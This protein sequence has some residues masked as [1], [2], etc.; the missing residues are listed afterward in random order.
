MDP[1]SSRSHSPGEDAHTIKMRVRLI[2]RGI[3]PTR[4][5]PNQNELSQV[6]AVDTPAS[7]NRAFS[8]TEQERERK[9]T[10][11]RESLQRLFRSIALFTWEEHLNR[12][13]FSDIDTCRDG[14]GHS[15]NHA[16]VLPF[17]LRLWREQ[18]QMSSNVDGRDMKRRALS[19]LKEQRDQPP[20]GRLFL[21][22]ARARSGERWREI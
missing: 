8:E 6:L 17:L 11:S 10:H 4:F 20:K 9:R 22:L 7:Q 15:L 2:G 21:P 13:F 14:R 19:Y 16:P 5:Y 3:N 12:N 1:I 18:D